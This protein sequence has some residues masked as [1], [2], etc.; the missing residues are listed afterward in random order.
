MISDDQIK[1]WQAEIAKFTNQVKKENEGKRLESVI[2]C[3]QQAHDRLT[4][5]L[6]KPEKKM[7]KTVKRALPEKE[8][9]EDG[10]DSDSEE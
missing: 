9:D 6:T 4:N 3:L 10:D 7:K 8:S 2:S 5:H 1:E